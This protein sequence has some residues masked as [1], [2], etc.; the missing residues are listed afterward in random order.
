LQTRVVTEQKEKL[1]LQSEKPNQMN[2]DFGATNQRN[3]DVG[4]M[5]GIEREECARIPNRRSK[6]MFKVDHVRC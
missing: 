4:A 6:D 1:V 5:K 2:V 3:M